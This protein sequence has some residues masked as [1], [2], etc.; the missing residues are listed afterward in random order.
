MMFGEGLDNAQIL[1]E[2]HSPG[3]VQANG[4]A[5]AAAVEVVEAEDDEMMVLEGAIGML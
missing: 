5:R 1:H 2:K 4:L 3:L